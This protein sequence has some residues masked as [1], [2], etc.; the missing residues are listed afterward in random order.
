MLCSITISARARTRMRAECIDD[1]LP[2]P[3]MFADQSVTLSNNN[4]STFENR[5]QPPYQEQEV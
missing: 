2:L 3:Y 4:G 5:M 1:G